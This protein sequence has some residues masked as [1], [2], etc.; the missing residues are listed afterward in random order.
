MDLLRLYMKNELRTEITGLYF[1]TVRKALEYSGV[2]H[3]YKRD[4]TLANV[5]RNFRTVLERVEVRKD[6][7]PIV[8][9]EKI[10]LKY[11]SNH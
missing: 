1:D 3:C 9:W 4:P 7:G 5:A 10:F 2:L 11:L 8:I 6:D